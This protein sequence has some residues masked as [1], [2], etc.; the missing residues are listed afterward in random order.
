MDRN[1]WIDLLADVWVQLAP[2]VPASDRLGAHWAPPILDARVPALC[3]DC[4]GSGEVGDMPELRIPSVS[5]DHPSVPTVEQVLAA[6]MRV[7]Q[8]EWF[9]EDG[10]IVVVDGFTFGSVAD[11]L[12]ALRGEQ[13]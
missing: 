12:A 10:S 8:A 2:G 1:D 11:L 4:K 3:P 6:G 9:E 7:Y 13:P 5:C